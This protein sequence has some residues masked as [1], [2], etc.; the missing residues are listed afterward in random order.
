MVLKWNV[1]EDVC[2]IH[3]GFDL[4][5]SQHQKGLRLH[6][7][8]GRSLVKVS[9][10]TGMCGCPFLV[11]VNTTPSAGSCSSSCFYTLSVLNVHCLFWALFFINVYYARSKVGFK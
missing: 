11:R 9:Y 7:H 10:V 8:G 3:V 4:Y 6:V 2:S 1:F 5:S